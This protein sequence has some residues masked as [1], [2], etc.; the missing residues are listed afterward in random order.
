LKTKFKEVHLINCTE[1]TL[2]VYFSYNI[3]L[4]SIYYSTIVKSWIFKIGENGTL[5]CFL[6]IFRKYISLKVYL[7]FTI[8]YFKY[9]L[10]ALKDI[11]FSPGCIYIYTYIYTHIYTYIYIYIYIYEYIYIVSMLI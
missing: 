8:V 6:Y 2:K 1:I 4:E 10:N 11:L 7:K 5:V 9:I 3:F